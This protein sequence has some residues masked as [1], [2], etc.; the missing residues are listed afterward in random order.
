[1]SRR[2]R[3]RAIAGAETGAAT[4]MVAYIEGLL[5]A[6]QLILRVHWQQVQQQL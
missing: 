5:A 6:G 4:S 1:M 2:S 3:G